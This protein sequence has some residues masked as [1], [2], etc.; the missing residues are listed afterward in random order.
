[1]SYP[2]GRLVTTFSLCVKL[3]IVLAVQMTDFSGR[4][5]IKAFDAFG[6]YHV[7]FWN[8]QIFAKL[9]LEIICDEK[10][11]SNELGSADLTRLVLGL[12]KFA[13]LITKTVCAFI[14]PSPVAST[15][16]HNDYQKSRA[17]IKETVKRA[18]ASIGKDLLAVSDKAINFVFFETLTEPKN[19][20]EIAK[21][22]APK[23]S[24]SGFPAYFDSRILRIDS[25]Y[26]RIVIKYFITL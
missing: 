10:V 1:M 9:F 24:K 2:W 16:W 20:T 8:C 26:I 12:L 11:T 5:L 18:N 13:R 19:A 14:I 22:D 6:K 23:R 25:L 4:Q 15:K 3:V 21:L 17:L 7:I